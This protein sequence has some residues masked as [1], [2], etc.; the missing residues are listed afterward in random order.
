MKDILNTRLLKIMEQLSTEDILESRKSRNWEV[1]DKLS[2][3]EKLKWRLEELEIFEDI[4]R[5]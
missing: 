3:I 4:I 1:F 2:E 5:F